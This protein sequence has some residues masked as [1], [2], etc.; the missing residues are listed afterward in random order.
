MLQT[1]K[2][3]EQLKQLDAKK[4]AQKFQEITTEELKKPIS[5]L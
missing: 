4:V 3:E 2:W 5:K 1:Q